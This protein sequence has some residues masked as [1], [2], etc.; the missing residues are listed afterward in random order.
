MAQ[1]I[2]ATFAGYPVLSGE[3][4]F[5]LG[6]APGSGT[7]EFA[8]TS[9]NIPKK[10]TLIFND[11]THSIALYDIFAMNKRIESDS[12]SGVKLVCTIYDRRWAWKYGAMVGTYN[13]QDVNGVPEKAQS[14]NVL[15]AKCFYELNETNYTFLGLPTGDAKVYPEVNWEYD[16]PGSAMQDILDKAGL[17]LGTDLVVVVS[18]LCLPITT[19]VQCQ[20]LQRWLPQ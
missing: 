13:K 9:Y 11:G 4:S 7:L 2:T 5:V 15:L 6:I 19:D 20:V 16:N 8:N 3:F 1:T 14:I 18:L 10:G 12:V 17:L